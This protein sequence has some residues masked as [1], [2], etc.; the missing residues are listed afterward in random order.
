MSEALEWRVIFGRE[1]AFLDGVSIADAYPS[2]GAEQDVWRLRIWRP[3]RV[4]GGF[5]AYVLCPAG[6][7]SARQALVKLLEQARREGYGR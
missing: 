7:E 5:E 4:Q 2:K 6:A 3:G 1:T